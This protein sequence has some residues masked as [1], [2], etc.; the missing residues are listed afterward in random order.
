M[1]NNMP[2]IEKYR[3]TNFKDII[4]HDEIINT[5]EKL[6]SCKKFPHTIFFGPPGTGKTSTIIACAREIYGNN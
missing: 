5:F 6:I 1:S 2:W 3:P 4:S